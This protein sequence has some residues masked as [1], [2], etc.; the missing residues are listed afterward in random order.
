MKSV[1]YNYKKNVEGIHA[2]CM[3][4]FLYAKSDFIKPMES[5][6]ANLVKVIT[7]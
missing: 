2:D 5:E 3:Q 7:C 4:W 6:Y 1:Y